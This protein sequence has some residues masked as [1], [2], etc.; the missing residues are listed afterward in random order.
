M[1]LSEVIAK[2]IAL[3]YT[4]GNSKLLIPRFTSHSSPVK[5]GS[6][7]QVNEL[8]TPSTH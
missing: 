5:P 3:I 8:G 6:Q 1:A 4:A 2:E 7:T